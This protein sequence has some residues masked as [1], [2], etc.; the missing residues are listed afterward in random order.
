MTMDQLARV[1]LDAEA[2]AMTEF[3]E[4]EGMD[5]PLLVDSEDRH[6][7]V[8]SERN[9]VYIDGSTHMAQ[10]HAADQSGSTGGSGGPGAGG[11]G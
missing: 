3:F 2:R 11:G 6:P 7:R 4:R 1:R 8:G 9:G 10:D 5:Y